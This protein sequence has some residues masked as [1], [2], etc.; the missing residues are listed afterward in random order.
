MARAQTNSANAQRSTGPRTAAGKARASQNA[1]RHGLRSAAPL[2][3]GESAAEWEGF[4]EG[5]VRSVGPATPLEAELAG[6]VALSLWRLR[7]VRAFEAAAA[8]L[9]EE[10]AVEAVGGADGCPGAG[11]AR[12]AEALR[13]AREAL[14]KQREW[15]VRREGTLALL[16]RLPDLPDAEAVAGDAVRAVLAEVNT[17]LEEVAGDYVRVEG[18]PF[19]TAVG[20]PAGEQHAP[21]R[22]GGWTAGLARRA[23]DRMAGRF[24]ACP[25]KVLAGALRSSEEGQAR[26]EADCGRLEQ[27]AAGLEAR[28]R[29]LEARARLRHLLPKDAA[30]EKV[31]RY[32][33]HLSRQMLQALHTLERLQAHRRGADVPPPAALD[34]TVSGA[35]PA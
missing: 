14:A 13:Q 10:E 29:T 5:V 4:E 23:V 35:G 22:W 16:R 32:E 24:K 31:V 27:E 20:V 25:H 30:L 21:W 6:R 28:V 17:E 11:R 12:A 8:A 18:G 3:P 7:R 9:D 2:L 26:W 33:A 15:L 19:L 34:V 1:V